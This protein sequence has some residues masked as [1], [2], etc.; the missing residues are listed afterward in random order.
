VDGSR[1]FVDVL[2][3]CRPY[4]VEE[5]T[6]AVR[7][8][9]SFPEPSL[10]VVRFQL[11][12]AVEESQPRPQAIDYPGPEVRLGSTAAYEQLLSQEEYRG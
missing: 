10:G 11:W 4:G 1:T 3:L 6:K 2:Q 5:V 8:A 9:L 7:T 12:N